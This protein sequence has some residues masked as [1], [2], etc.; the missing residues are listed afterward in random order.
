MKNWLVRLSIFL[1]LLAVAQVLISG[2]YPAE[3]PPEI[4]RLDAYL[5]DQV[6]VIYFG[7][8]T[9]TYPLGEVTTGQILQEMLPDG[10]VGC[11]FERD[12]Y[13]KI[14]FARFTLDWLTDGKDTLQK[15]E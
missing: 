6:D 4:L 12:G 10:T 1:L 9:L 14:T 3:V 2:L 5:A 8:S 15:K 7:D 11:L 13:A